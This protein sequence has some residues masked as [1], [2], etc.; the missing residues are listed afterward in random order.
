MRSYD[1]Y[2]PVAKALDVIGERWTLL[3][4]HQLMDGPLRFTDLEDRLDGIGTNIL[5]ARLKKL[6]ADGVLVKKRLK[7]PFASTVYELT[8]AGRALRV[9][10]QDLARWG[11]AL[12]PPPGDEHLTPGWL[13]QAVRVSAP[14]D[15]CDLPDA[16]IAFRSG[17]EEATLR[18]SGGIVRVEGEADPGADATIAGEPAAYYAWLAE[19]D[20]SGLELAGDTTLL[21]R[22]L[23]DLIPHP[24]PA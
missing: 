7:P 21:E 19:R 5:S 13:V 6:E 16:A 24:L 23:V 15:H 17:G 14:A 11:L 9:V 22:V 8:D 18:I 1:R 3:L 2:C 4:V 12:L 10:I 20:P